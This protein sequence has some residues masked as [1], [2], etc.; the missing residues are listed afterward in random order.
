[1]G[2]SE[3]NT[4]REEKREG[5]A[6]RLWTPGSE[7]RSEARSAEKSGGEEISEEELR[8][9]L[10]EA[11]E[12]ITVT[13]VVVDMMISLSSLAYQ[14]MGIPHEVNEKHRDLDQSRMAIDCLAALVNTVE[15]RVPAEILD[16]LKGNVD[17]LKMNF[18]KES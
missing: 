16:P 12:K 7:E 2:N 5:A 10:E 9:R 14:R 6:S 3:E 13:D 15:G 1:M 17:N 18:A 8:R 11:M 4:G